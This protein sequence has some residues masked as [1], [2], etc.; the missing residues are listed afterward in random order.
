MVFLRRVSRY[1]GR[2]FTC[3]NICWPI[4]SIFQIKRMRKFPSNIVLSRISDP[5]ISFTEGLAIS[6]TTPFL[7]GGITL[8]LPLIIFFDIDATFVSQCRIPYSFMRP[9]IIMINLVAWQ[10]S[11]IDVLQAAHDFF[12][13][14]V[15]QV[16]LY[17][18][19]LQVCLERLGDLYQ[20]LGSS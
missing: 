19:I 18:Y 13:I 14:G 17:S 20:C 1:V 11:C 5:T 9:D 16:L 8:N 12:F 15:H 6:A 3:S 2:L 7:R 4:I 10:Y